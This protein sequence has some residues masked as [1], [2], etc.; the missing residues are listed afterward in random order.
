MGLPQESAG[1]GME[2]GKAGKLF[3]DL[4][5]DKGQS[6]IVIGRDHL[7]AGRLPLTGRPNP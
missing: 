3:N 1:W 2:K 5:R 7:T 4:V 6:P